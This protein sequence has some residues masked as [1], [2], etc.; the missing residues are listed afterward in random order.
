MAPLV[1]ITGTGTDVGKTH[2]ACALLRAWGTRSLVVGFKPVETGVGPGPRDAERLASASTFH[3]KPQTQTFDAPLAPPLA[4]QLE[5]RE[6]DVP[7]ILRTAATL[8]EGAGGVVI[9]LAGGLFSPLATDTLNA[10]I[11]RQLRPTTTL[12]VAP[13]RLGVLHDLAATT[14]AAAHEGVALFGIILN[15]P[16]VNDRSTGTNSREARRVTRL[17]I[18]ASLPRAPE[19]VLASALT[20]LLSTV[21]RAG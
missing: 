6:V 17:P 21:L 15:A 5:G 19:N 11:V 3:V 8:R 1:I 2:V 14:R 18:L 16:G 13:D 10:D 12:L 7:L 20:A 4:A 9:E